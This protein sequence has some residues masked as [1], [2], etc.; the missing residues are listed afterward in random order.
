[1]QAIQHFEGA[2][3]FNRKNSLE[4]TCEK[5]K[6]GCKGKNCFSVCEI[7][8]EKKFLRKISKLNC[9]DSKDSFE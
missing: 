6:T 7:C 5:R 1:M 3:C 8:S 2:P 4:C 9:S